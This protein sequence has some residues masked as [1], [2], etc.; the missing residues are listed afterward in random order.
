MIH[1]LLITEAGAPDFVARYEDTEMAEAFSADQRAA[2]TAGHPVTIGTV[3]FVDMV[4][5]ARIVARRTPA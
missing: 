1:H 2:L 5:A 3:R 4:A